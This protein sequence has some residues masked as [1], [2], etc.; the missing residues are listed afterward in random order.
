MEVRFLIN[1]GSTG[2]VFRRQLQRDAEAATLSPLMR[3]Y[4]GWAR[5]WL[6]LRGRQ[7]L[8]SLRKSKGKLG[9]WYLPTQFMDALEA[10]VA[11]HE[12]GIPLIHPWPDGASYAF[13][14]THDVEDEPGVRHCLAL[15]DLEEELGLRSSFNFVPYKYKVDQGVVREL[16]ARGFEIGIHGYNHDG[17]LFS[18]RNI[19][20]RRVP[21]IN[22]AA[23]RYGTVGFRSAMVHRNLDWLQDLEVEYDASYFDIDPYQAMPGGVGSL[24]P[25]IAGHFVELPYTLPQDHT[26]LIVLGEASTRIWDE[27]LKY[28][29]RRSGMALML[30]HPDYLLDPDKLKLYRDFLARVNDAG[31]FWHALPRDVAR[32][33][34]RR[35]E[36]SLRLSP[37]NRAWIEGPAAER[38]RPAILRR[39]GQHL[40]IASL[41]STDIV[42]D[43][44][45]PAG[46][47]QRK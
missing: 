1:D 21:S 34:R 31:G 36:S 41:D 8:Q 47:S 25:F 35:D 20:K 42:S 30:T 5:P 37:G 17:R 27:K 19:F 11:L 18:S 43:G 33:W 40:E 14:L 4:Y 45:Q 15:A 46:F 39:G 22:D 10:S 28:I 3:F 23:Q 26:L 9:G 44:S 6:P 29:Q 24:W 2:E 12:K 38:G 13:V 16:Q 32:W 7:L